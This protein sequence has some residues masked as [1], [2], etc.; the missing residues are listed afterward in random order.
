MNDLTCQLA[1]AALRNSACFCVSL[2]E[3]ALRLAL[4]AQLEQP[5]IAELVRQRCPYLFAARPV[6]LST[7]RLMRMEELVQTI[8]S[9]VALPAYRE[10][11]L[12]YAPDIARH[13]TGA[14]GVFM[15]YDFH[16]DDEHFGL[17]EINTNAGGAMLNAVLARAQ[18]A[19]CAEAEFLV[20]PVAT[21]GA[22]EREIIAMFRREWAL[23]G[24][25]RPLRSIAI[26]DDAP[27]QQYLYPEFL[28]FQQLFERHDLRAVIAAPDQFTLEG[29]ALWHD[30][31]P[32]DLVYNRLTDFA[33]EDRKSVV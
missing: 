7:A 27:E 20:P 30:G 15:G 17:I 16:A 2:D 10:R 5:D 25:E 6:F 24:H 33:L 18:R 11:V 8:E 13:D 21:A 4:N 1:P 14:H 9:V 28:L 32:I 12:A 3:E 29:G 31:Q 23:A 22:F 26:V 19:C